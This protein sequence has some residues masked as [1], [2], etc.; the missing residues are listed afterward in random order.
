MRVHARERGFVRQSALNTPLCTVLHPLPHHGHVRPSLRVHFLSS[1]MF[2]PKIVPVSVLNM[3]CCWQNAHLHTTTYYTQGRAYAR[4]HQPTARFACQFPSSSPP[5]TPESPSLSL[6][7]A[8]KKCRTA[9]WSYDVASIHTMSPSCMWLLLSAKKY[10][11]RSRS[12][13]RC[14]KRMTNAN[15]KYTTAG[16]CR[17]RLC[18]STVRVHATM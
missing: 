5:S 13:A 12:R 10:R 17:V 4:W 16:V 11:K 6:D 8:P 7:I 14:R 15:G 1:S 9:G 18:A 2:V 3:S